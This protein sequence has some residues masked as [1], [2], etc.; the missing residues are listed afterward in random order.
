ME[1]TALRRLLIL[2]G[3]QTGTAKEVAEQIARESKRRHFQPRVVGMDTYATVI[4][5]CYL[6][7]F[8]TDT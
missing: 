1:D 2:Y 6:I 5:L 3:T 8:G 7:I 4:L